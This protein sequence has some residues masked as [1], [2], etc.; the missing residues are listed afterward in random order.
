MIKFNPSTNKQ[1]GGHL[2]ITELF[3]DVMEIAGILFINP[4][5]GR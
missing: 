3:Y 5:K 4:K 2:V 1:M